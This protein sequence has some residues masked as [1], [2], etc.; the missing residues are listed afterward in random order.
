MKKFWIQVLKRAVPYAGFTIGIMLAE[1][2][3]KHIVGR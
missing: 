3:W 1:W 2:L